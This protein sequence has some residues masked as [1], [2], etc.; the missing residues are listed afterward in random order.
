KISASKWLSLIKLF[1]LSISARRASSEVKL[2]YDT[3]LRAFDI[4]RLS[5]LHD[6]VLERDGKVSVDIV[7][8]VSAETL[9]NET[10]KKARRGSIVYTDKWRSYDSLTFC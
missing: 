8:D 1:E 7:K 4:I 6:S 5:I 10:V 2:S 9:M 3:A